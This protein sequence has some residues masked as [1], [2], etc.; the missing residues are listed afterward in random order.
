MDAV[1][2]HE[3]LVRVELYTGKGRP[4]HGTVFYHKE[5]V[6]LR[7]Q[8]DTGF[9]PDQRVVTPKLAKFTHRNTAGARCNSEACD[10]P[11]F[12]G[13][14]KEG[15]TL[16]CG[17]V[18]HK[19]CIIQHV[20]GYDLNHGKYS[21]YRQCPAQ[22][23]DQ[24]IWNLLTGEVYVRLFSVAACPPRR[25]PPRAVSRQT[26]VS[27]WFAPGFHGYRAWNPS[28][29]SQFTVRCIVSASSIFF[30]FF[31]FFFFFLLLLLLL[32]PLILP[33]LRSWSFHCL[34][35]RVI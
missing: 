18:F 8:H 21:E 4:L 24:D 1:R 33:S 15:L 31:F 34:Y 25:T 10:S 11:D 32:P 13:K 7:A 28:G 17:H 30:F 29:W 14:R 9:A 12:R 5:K 27:S 6:M 3:T 22:H 20:Q 35:C 23:C 16:T 2:Y 19:N 26:G